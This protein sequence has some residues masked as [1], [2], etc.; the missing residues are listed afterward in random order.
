MGP[1]QLI[2]AIVE[3]A[4]RLDIEVRQQP[5]GGGGGGLCRLRG[6]LIMFIDT[7]ADSQQ[8]LWRLCRDLS[9][10]LDLQNVY[11]LP[12]LREAI[13]RYGR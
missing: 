7:E 11:M 2:D 10:E 12:Q 3:L 1:A 8:M 5:L 6:K 13:E 9:R 4:E